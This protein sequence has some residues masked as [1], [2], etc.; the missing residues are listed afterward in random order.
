MSMHDEK[1][2]KTMKDFV[3]G[4]MDIETFKYEFDSNSIIKETL[5]NDPLCPK[6]THYL[7]PDD[8]N[9]VRV[10]EKQNW[11]QK[12]DQLTVWGEIR[13][14]LLRYNYPCVP[15]KYYEDRYSFLVD[16]QPNWLDITDEDFLNEQIVTKVPEGLSKTKRIQWCKARLKEM[17]R[18]DKSYPR[19]VQSPEWPILDGK[20][21]VFKTQM[22][23]K[24][25]M[26]RVDFVFYDPDTEAEH[27]VTQWY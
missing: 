13:K 25:D 23:D 11:L 27:I 17:F 18:Y 16:I 21:L 14:F 8:K 12:G 22:M 9:V 4:T 15:T 7:L 3:E 6:G 10:L 24:N 2:I 1:A 26:E 19:W 20:P 5:R